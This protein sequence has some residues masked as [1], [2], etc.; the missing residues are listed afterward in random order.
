MFHGMFTR[1][2]E[3]L[4]ATVLAALLIYAWI[5]LMTRVSGL[6]T[7]AKMSSVDLAVTIAI[8]SVIAT[9]VL[10]PAGNF[11]QGIVALAAMF[12]IQAA[13]AH[14]RTRTPA[15][16][17][18][19]TN[20]PMFLMRDGVVLHDNLATAKVAYPDLLAKLRGAGITSFDEVAAVVFETTGDVSVLKGTGGIDPGILRGVEGGGGGTTNAE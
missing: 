5:V 2:W 6:R 17:K 13:F 4:V 20:T 12:A 11:I 18:L 3:D 7:F 10:D 19:V 14:A 1:A 8:G 16:Q 9:T 15:F